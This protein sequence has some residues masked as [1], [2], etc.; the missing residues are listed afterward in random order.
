MRLV[1]ISCARGSLYQR[2]HN[3]QQR[4]GEAEWWPSTSSNVLEMVQCLADARVITAELLGRICHPFLS[5]NG[6]ISLLEH[7]CKGWG[8]WEPLGWINVKLHCCHFVE[9]VWILFRA[10]FA[11]QLQ[12]HYIIL[13]RCMAV[14][15]HK[16]KCHTLLK[17]IH[18]P[19]GG[20]CCSRSWVWKFS[21]ASDHFI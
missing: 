7:C 9:I 2:V 14:I 16:L 21:S 1:M 20:I 18:F 13:L 19:V 5:L 10:K 17:R 3:S 6:S 4:H 11:R 8:T 12:A 15:A